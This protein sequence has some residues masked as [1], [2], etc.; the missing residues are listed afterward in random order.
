MEK[1]QD[2]RIEALDSTPVLPIRDIK[3]YISYE[4]PNVR[5]MAILAQLEV[6]RYRKI[7]IQF[8]LPISEVC[9]D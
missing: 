3:T 5:S 8:A 4:V 6:R 2:R 1:A 9:I 7:Q